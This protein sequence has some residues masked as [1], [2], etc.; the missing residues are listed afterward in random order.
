[1][2]T[3]ENYPEECIKILGLFAKAGRIN[4]RYK[5]YEDSFEDLSENGA[6]KVKRKLLGFCGHGAIKSLD[7]IARVLSET[8]VAQTSEEAREIVPQLAELGKVY[9]YAIRYGPL[10][11]LKFTEIKNKPG[12][13]KYH[14]MAWAA[15]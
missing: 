5:T 11:Y 14:V 12:E 3:E 15:D 8:G 6:K 9:S 10:N 2:I 7:E 13:V 1:M 4:K